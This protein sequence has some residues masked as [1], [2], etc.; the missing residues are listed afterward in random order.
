MEKAAF[1][2]AAL[3]VGKSLFTK[4]VWQT[5]AKGGA[6]LAARPGAMGTVGRG[7][8]TTANGMRRASMPL[9]AYGA[10]GMG[11][12]AMGYNLPGSDLAFNAATPGWGAMM[13]APSAIRSGRLAS[14]NYNDAIAADAQQGAGWAARDW[15]EATHN[16]PAAAYDPAAYRGLMQGGG[17]DQTGVDRYLQNRPVPQ[18]GWWNRL[19]NAFEDPTANVIPEVQRRIQGQLHKGA[20][21]SKEAM[22]AAA[23]AAWQLSRAASPGMMSAVTKAAPA[24]AKAGLKATPVIGPHMGNIRRYGGHAITAG[25]LG[26]GAYSAG[27]AYTEEKPYD[28]TAVQQEGYDGAQAGIQQRLGDLTPFQRYMAKFDPSLAVN[29]MEQA[30]PGSIQA[31]EQ[32][33]GRTYQPGFLGRM[34]N[35]W[36]G[37][38]KPNYF[39][40]D[41]TGATHYL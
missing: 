5:A 6:R 24:A 25:F 27:Q 29:R 22:A 26:S 10:A 3:N 23:K 11:A 31:W 35:A 18:Q 9:L 12:D 2:A 32:Q 4:G 36:Q 39:S 16:D 19:G 40:Y 15:I 1:G 30:M 28:V 37:R 17:F 41:S 8:E 7:I 13:V 38:S 21:M 33:Y 34:Q 20:S 14:G